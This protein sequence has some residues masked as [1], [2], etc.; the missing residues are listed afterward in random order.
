[1]LL[2]KLNIKIRLKKNIINNSFGNYF[3]F[4]N[5]SLLTRGCLVKEYW[6]LMLPGCEAGPD[7][8]LFSDK[9][10]CKRYIVNDK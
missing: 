5:N 4:Q 2:Y 6:I 10:Y 8:E 1:M 9:I 3:I 7:M